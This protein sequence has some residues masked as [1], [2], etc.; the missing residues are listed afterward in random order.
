MPEIYQLNLSELIGAYAE[1][2]IENTQAAFV[3][4]TEGELA[5]SQA[6]TAIK[7]EIDRRIAL[8]QN[9]YPLAWKSHLDNT[10]NSRLRQRSLIEQ[11]E[12]H[13]QA[14]T[15]FGPWAPLVEQCRAWP[16]DTPEEGK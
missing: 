8:A 16:L 5:A 4:D 10:V 6:E 3:M 12:R 9:D 1:A 7:A 14:A 2:C 11:A 15:H 13:R